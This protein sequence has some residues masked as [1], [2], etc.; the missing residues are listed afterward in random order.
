[1][2]LHFSKKKKKKASTLVSMP[3]G[4]KLASSLGVFSMMKKKNFIC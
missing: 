2:Q 3:N 4:P 1:M